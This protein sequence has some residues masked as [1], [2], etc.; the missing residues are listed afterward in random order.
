MTVVKG[1]KGRRFIGAIP[2]VSGVDA[3]PFL[4]TWETGSRVNGM[5]PWQSNDSYMED[6]IHDVQGFNAW[7]DG[8]TDN[9]YNDNVKIQD[10]T[11]YPIRI[12]LRKY[13]AKVSS[14]RVF[15]RLTYYHTNFYFI[16]KGE[17][18]RNL[19]ATIS[20]TT[21]G[22]QTINL[23]Q[24]EDVTW[25]IIETL[26]K[27][28]SPNQVEINGSYITPSSII[29]TIRK[30]KFKKTTWQNIFNWN[31]LDNDGRPY[32]KQQ[33]VDLLKQHDGVR[34]YLDRIHLEPFQGDYY[35]QPSYN[36]AGSW[37]LDEFYQLLKDNNIDVRVCI[38]NFPS[39]FQAS[40]P[41]ELQSSEQLPVTYQSTR[42]TTTAWAMLPEAYLA[43]GKLFFQFAARYG[44][45][46][47]ADNL[48]SVHTEV[49]GVFPNNTKRTGLNLVSKIE[50]T[51]EPDSWWHGWSGFSKARQMA[52]RMSCVWDGHKG[53]LGNNVGVKTADPNMS[54]S[55]P[56][57]A[58]ATFEEI[59]SMLDWFRENRGYKQDGS[60]DIP[61]D[62][63]NYHMYSNDAGSNQYG[64]ATRGM[65]PETSGFSDTMKYFTN[66]SDEHMKGMPIILGEYGY[67]ISQFSNQRA[68]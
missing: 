66:L 43:E 36:G 29:P 27:D 31:V 59:L 16:R 67:D 35:F 26:H 19:I 39:S 45:T 60:I 18:T 49:G 40:W 53:A 58:V 10:N 33:R 54:L 52:A 61:F 32:T 57:L 46:V 56:G 34:H 6:N 4:A 24:T 25:I 5:I 48:L 17:F 62:C 20:E 38:K 3:D 9:Y 51:N 55:M 7:R 44:S 65:P 14:L 21:T 68:A 41:S 30:P 22:W 28:D 23:P 12:H 2:P 37:P 13:K 11:T 47:V 42:D 15:F 8:T 63:I 1:F 64:S 50:C